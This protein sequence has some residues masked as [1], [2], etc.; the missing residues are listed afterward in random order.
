MKTAL[1]ILAIVATLNILGMLFFMY[2]ARKGTLVLSKTSWHI[3]LL[4]WMWDVDLDAVKNGCP[5]YWS[6]ALSLDILPVYLLIR[7]IIVGGNF[8]DKKFKKL[9]KL[10][11][12]HLPINL[13]I[14]ETKREA[15]TVVYRKG[16]DI[17]KTLFA[18]ILAVIA[19]VFIVLFLYKFFVTAGI[20]GVVVLASVVGFLSATLY[21]HAKH[22]E[23]DHYHIDHYV[24]LGK[25]MWGIFSLPF[26]IAGYITN[27]PLK[28]FISWYDKSC[29][30]VEF[31]D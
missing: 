18:V 29:P 17:T 30:P 24:G 10:P 12:I 2:K 20:I 9:P 21:A 3:K 22:P 13:Q 6:L 16:K 23:L 4:V 7:G 14:P 27:I 8:L 15:Y 1:L 19:V 11:K 26:I 25:S 31:V 28:K 5:Y